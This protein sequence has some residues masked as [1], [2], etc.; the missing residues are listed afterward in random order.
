MH[1]ESTLENEQV[2]LDSKGEPEYVVLPIARYQKLLQLLEDYGLG[3]AISEAENEPHYSKSEAI[4][5]I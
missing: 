2:I 5:L 3:Q 4:A 1:K